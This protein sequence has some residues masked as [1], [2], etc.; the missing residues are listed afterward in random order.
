MQEQHD[1]GR[2][3]AASSD[4]FGEMASIGA[5]AVKLADGP[6]LRRGYPPY[7]VWAEQSAETSASRESCQ[8]RPDKKL[9]CFRGNDGWVAGMTGGSRE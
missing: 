5:C 6:R 3:S 4:A 8:W 9:P 7:V 2:K 1:L